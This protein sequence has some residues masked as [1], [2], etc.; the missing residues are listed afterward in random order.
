MAARSQLAETNKKKVRVRSYTRLTCVRAN[1]TSSITL[2]FREWRAEIP[3][4]ATTPDG[5]R[6]NVVPYYT[7]RAF[8]WVTRD[9]D[10][11]FSSSRPPHQERPAFFFSPSTAVAS[12]GFSPRCTS[13]ATTF[14][15]EHMLPKGWGRFLQRRKNACRSSGSA[16]KFSGH[17]NDRSNAAKLSRSLP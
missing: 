11:A 16:E 1:V 3:L 4:T 2:S 5:Y 15:R 12:P 8:I 13:D 6:N 7:H 10:P 14:S 9:R 17:A